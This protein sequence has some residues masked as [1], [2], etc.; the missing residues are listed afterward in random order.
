MGG[1]GPLRRQAACLRRIDLA[2]FDPRH[3]TPLGIFLGANS[4][5]EGGTY[6]QRIRAKGPRTT[7]QHYPRKGKLAGVP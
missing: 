1:D 6:G 3:G 7:V 2:R 5:T 4:C